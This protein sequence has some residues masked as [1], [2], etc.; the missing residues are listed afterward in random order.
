[1]NDLEVDEKIIQRIRKERLRIAQGVKELE[2]LDI[3]PTNSKK[4][5]SGS[6]LVRIEDVLKVINP[7]Q[8]VDV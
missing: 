7:T 5:A 1:M 8:G 4:H 2:L 6:G 3:N